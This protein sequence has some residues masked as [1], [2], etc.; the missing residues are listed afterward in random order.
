MKKLI[1]LKD[2]KVRK[3]IAKAFGVTLGNLT[4]SLNFQRNGDKNVKQ[5]I[6]AM[7]NGGTLMIEV[8]NWDIGLL[9]K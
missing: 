7:K 8:E 9:K 5:R 6:A 2:S 1:I 4:Q 3:N